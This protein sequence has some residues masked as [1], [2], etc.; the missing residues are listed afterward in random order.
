MLV[1]L[2]LSPPNKLFLTSTDERGPF[3]TGSH[4]WMMVQMG[5]KS[6]PYRLRSIDDLGKE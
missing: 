5:M 4:W 6:L 2:A 3:H 1:T